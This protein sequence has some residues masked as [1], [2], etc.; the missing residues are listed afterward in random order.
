MLVVDEDL[1]SPLN[2]SGVLLKYSGNILTNPKILNFNYKDGILTASEAMNLY[3]DKTQLVVL[4][5]CE[6]GLGDVQ[7]GEGVYG[8]QRSFLVAGANSVIMSLFKVNDEVTRKLMVSFYRHW[9]VSSNKRE[10]FIK[11]KKEI[12]KEYPEAIY[13]GAFVMIG[14]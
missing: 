1:K 4:S 3:M 8:L 2:R 12:K 9:I 13:W 6:T 14:N 5:A 10:S 11:A 7:A